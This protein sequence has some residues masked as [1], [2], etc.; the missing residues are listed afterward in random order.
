[1]G[2]EEFSFVQQGD[3]LQILIGLHSYILAQRG[4][5]T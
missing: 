4:Q 1:V 3:S 2:V 5:E